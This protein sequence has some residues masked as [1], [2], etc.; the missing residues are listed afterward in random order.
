MNDFKAFC[1]RIGENPLRAGLEKTPERLDELESFLYS[2]YKLDPISA[3]GT[4]LENIEKI[5][6]MISLL[7]IEFYSMCEHHLLPFFGHI[8]IGYIPNEKL[9]GISGF[10]RLAEVFSRRLQI[11]ENLTAQIANTIMEVLKPKGV[12]VI[13]QA[14]HL[15]MAMRG[16][17]KQDS[18]IKTSAARGLFK[19]DPKTRAEF[20]ALLK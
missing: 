8:H 11:Q 6:E 17:Q 19:S 7:N 15:C 1:E 4:P 12:M 16:L 10:A 3:L 5:D 20:L 18:I 9:A 2:G 14:K 13:A